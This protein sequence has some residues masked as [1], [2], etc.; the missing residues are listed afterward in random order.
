MSV[1]STRTVMEKYANSEHSD[2]TMMANDVVFKIMATGDEHSTP[3]GVLNLFNFF[4][5]I[6]FDATAENLNLVVDDGRAAL[7]CVF[8]GTHIGEFVGIPPTGKKVHVPLLVFYELENDQ[9][10]RARVY[11]DMMAMMSQLG[12]SAPAATQA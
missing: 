12:V 7:E 1:E 11:L 3:Q 2:V 4:Y 10:K 6:A 9:I 8:V 5:R